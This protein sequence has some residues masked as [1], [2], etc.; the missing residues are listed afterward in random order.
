VAVALMIF[1]RRVRGLEGVVRWWW[2][3][4]V[5]SCVVL[6]PLGELAVRAESAGGSGSGSWGFAVMAD[7]RPSRARY[8]AS[9][10][11]RGS[12][13]GFRD[14]LVELKRLVDSPSSDW[15]AP[16]FLVICGDID[17]VGYCDSE[18]RA[19]MGE[20]FCWVPVL[21]N[22]DL[23]SREGFKAILA[24]MMAGRVGPQGLRV[25]LGPKGTRY[26]QYM[27]SYRNGLLVITNAYW[28]GSDAEGAEIGHAPRQVETEKLRDGT[29]TQR[30]KY[31]CDGWI[32][33]GNLS[34]HDRVLSGSKV[35]HKFVFC[36]EP[37]W[38]F[39]RHEEDS[40]SD[41]PAS[42]DRFWALLGRTGVR[43]FFCGHSHW[44][45]TYRWPGNKG[46]DRWQGYVSSIIR[47]PVGVWQIDAGAA[48]GALVT[49]RYDR[50]I[51][52]VRV[53]SADV[54]VRTQISRRFAG[55]GSGRWEVPRNGTNVKGRPAMFDWSL[56]GNGSS[57]STR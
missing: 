22:H 29:T 7:P 4:C 16:A 34:W 48:R 14:D 42:R 1:A 24:E 9:D 44:Y 17:E 2:G 5:F 40:L 47:G 51:V 38:P 55:L 3:W 43:A 11:K 45:S 53:D 12:H 13:S 35:R 46:T 20:G 21:G 50:V 28:D 54:R 6:G 18:I 36:H 41:H 23:E 39:H 15:P 49:N 32:A 27:L 26:W 8:P 19:V 33:P 56:L 57:V 52:Q 30:V 25:T 37:C 31:A 10:R